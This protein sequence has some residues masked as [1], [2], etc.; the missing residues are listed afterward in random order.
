VR[1]DGLLQVGEAGLGTEEGAPGVHLVHQVVA[2]EVGVQGAGEGD[3]AGIVHQDVQ[4]AEGRHGLGHGGQH[5]VLGAHVADDGQGPPARRLHL[6]RGAEH[7]PRQPGVGRRGLAEDGDVGAVPGGPQG[8]GEADAAGGAGDE[9]GL[10]SQGH[11]SSRLRG[12]PAVSQGYLSRRTLERKP[13]IQ[14]QDGFQE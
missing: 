11:G 2:L 7:R 12:M 9:K 3:G 5:Q 10:P 14:P 4:A 6:R 1:I 8:D 13:F